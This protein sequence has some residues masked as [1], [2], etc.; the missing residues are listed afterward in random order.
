MSFL[1]CILYPLQ[2]IFLGEILGAVILANDHLLNPT[3]Q[4]KPISVLATGDVSKDGQIV[5]DANHGK[6]VNILDSLDP[7]AYYYHFSNFLGSK[8]Q[9]A[10]IGSFY[11]Q[12]RIWSRPNKTETGHVRAL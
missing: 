5:V 4:V 8:T 6:L 7:D 11:E 12:K 3:L 1:T 10:V 9:S 2:N